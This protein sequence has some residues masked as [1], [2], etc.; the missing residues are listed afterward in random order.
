MIEKKSSSVP[1]NPGVYF[2]C[3]CGKSQDGIFCDGSHKDT[4][5]SP[6]K[7]T[8][9]EP[10]IVSICMCRQSENLPFCDGSHKKI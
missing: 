7:F 6:K 3:R 9:T 2:Y 4:E 8:L 1:L 10:Q 5:F